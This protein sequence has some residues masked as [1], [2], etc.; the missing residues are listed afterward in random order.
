MQSRQYKAL[1]DDIGLKQHSGH[2]GIGF[3]QDRS[4]TNMLNNWERV[5]EDAAICG[6]EYV[7]L[8]WIDEK[9][10]KTL[11][12][13]K[14]VIDIMN[15]CALKAKQYNIQ[16][17]FHNHDFEFK[18]VEGVIPYDLMLKGTDK[19]LVKFELDHYWTT[20]AKVKSSKLI[21]SN[22]GRFPLFHLKDMKKKVTEFVEV[23]D[24]RINY[25]KIL[26]LSDIAKTKYFYVEQDN[27]YHL[28]P[29]E[30][31]ER[32]YNNLKMLKY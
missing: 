19:E 20:K 12:D 6:Q 13:Y 2:V 8:G 17:C 22:P 29:L 32:S 26:G 4:S 10:R 9:Y 14:R 5:L 24:G 23:G 11:D 25:A 31:I 3:D 16:F 7:V 27:T 21:K 15:N 18:P 1:L 30:S 28:S